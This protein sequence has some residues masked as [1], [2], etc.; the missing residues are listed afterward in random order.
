MKDLSTVDD[1]ADTILQ[2]ARL[3]HTDKFVSRQLEM[4]NRAEQGGQPYVAASVI[5]GAASHAGD[6]HAS[7]GTRQA[8]VS[9]LQC[10]LRGVH[11]VVE[12]E[13]CHPFCCVRPPGH[14][15]GRDGRTHDSP[16]QGFCFFNN[17]A[18]AAKY[19]VDRLGLQRV[20]VIDY[21]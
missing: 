12:R 14:H 20:A 9:S 8:V 3:A 21:D 11:A 2:Y 18:I 10:V 7:K 1:D 5:S 4:L 6:T 13:H 17:V 15:V 16:G 19:A